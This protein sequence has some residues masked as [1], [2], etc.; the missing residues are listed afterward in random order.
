M[1][2][3]KK[4]MINKVLNLKLAITLKYNNIFA[5]GYVRNW[6]EKIFL[7]KKVN[8]TVPWTYVISDFMSEIVGIL[9][10]KRLQKINKKSLELKLDKLYVKWKDYD[11]SLT[12]YF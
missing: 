10:K 11:N 8:C 7:I 5:E 1:L 12:D 3:L 4:S 2:T 6:Y 9:Y